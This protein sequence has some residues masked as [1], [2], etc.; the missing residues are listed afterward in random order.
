MRHGPDSGGQWRAMSNRVAAVLAGIVLVLV[1]GD[2]ALNG[3][4]GS[5]FLA[6]ELLDL[7]EYLSFW[8]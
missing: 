8:R 5:L 6:H 2:V 3:A 4:L 1:L 7:V